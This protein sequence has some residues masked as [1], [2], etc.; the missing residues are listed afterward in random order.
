VSAPARSSVAAA[1]RAVVAKFGIVRLAMLAIAVASLGYFLLNTGG[2]ALEATIWHAPLILMLLLVSLPW[3]TVSVRMVALFF[4]LGMGPVYLLTIL[5]QAALV[6]SPLDGALRSLSIDLWNAGFGQLG[7]IHANVWAPITEEILKVAP[8]LVLLLWRG[9][10]LRA[11]GGPLDLGIL[12]AATGAGLG[13]AEDMTI[14]IGR[15]AGFLETPDAALLGLGVGTLYIAL[16]VNPLTPG[17]IEAF[18]SFQLSYEGVVGIFLPSVDERLMTGFVW[19]G[20]GAY[21]LAV[22]IALGLAVVAAHRYGSRLPY[23]LPVVILAY[24]IIE[25]AL[26]NWYP[27][28]CQ[29]DPSQV[30]CVVAQLDFHGA[31]FPLL[32]IGG[33]ILATVVAQRIIA[34]H[35]AVDPH[36]YVAPR[37]LSLAAYRDAGLTAPL[38]LAADLLLYLRMR[39]RTAYGLYLLAP[40]ASRAIRQ[41]PLRLYATRLRALLL[42]ERLRGGSTPAVD[43]TVRDLLETHA[44]AR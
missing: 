14:L 8:L 17:H 1:A 31:I 3:R 15:F 32:A 41:R 16:V 20:H 33:W 38:R 43:D 7:D 11:M 42:A 23:F 12:A 27:S 10:A 18:P 36:A 9:T 28:T 39:N 37:A 34:R 30:L 44:P 13:V 22:G 19:A 4:F 6:A 35:R 25:H 29:S 24:A 2:R 26:R 5:S 40:D 21:P